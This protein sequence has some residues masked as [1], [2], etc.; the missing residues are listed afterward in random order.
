LSRREQWRLLLLV[1]SLGLVVVLMMEASNPD[2]YAWLWSRAE[3]GG[4]SAERPPEVA[5]IDT[6]ARPKPADTSSAA[7]EEGGPRGQY[8]AGVEPQL[9][10][11]VRDDTTFRYDERHAWFNLL[12]V[13]QDAS[14]QELEQASLG[15]ATYFQ[16]F[17]QTDEYRGSLVTIR[18]KVRRAHLLKTPKN[19]VGIK[20]YYQLWV[21]PDDA[22]GYPIVVYCLEL[23]E[24]FP[25]GMHIR[26]GAQITGFYFKRW[27]YKAP[28]ALRTAPTLAAKTVR[29]IKIPTRKRREWGPASIM[30][31]VLAAG[32]FALIACSWIY[33]R[34]RGE[35]SRPAEAEPEFAALQQPQ[36]EP[37]T[38]APPDHPADNQE[39]SHEE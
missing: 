11:S 2:N 23:P 26:E 29:W 9:L 34:T 15:R 20:E 35:P 38:R 39:S 27:A 16:L 10:E 6:R 30:I 3:G 32:V 28:N 22:E 24:G 13:L 25:L 4:D 17:E 37:E 18:G 21:Q 19:D 5:P 31:V 36:A 8:Y 1:L 14:E 33:L 12:G 7:G